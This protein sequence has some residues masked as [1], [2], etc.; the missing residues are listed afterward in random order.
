[1]ENRMRVAE[2]MNRIETPL[3]PA[4]TLFEAAQQ[5]AALGVQALPVCL[6]GKIVGLLTDEDLVFGAEQE[7]SDGDE[8]PATAGRVDR[9]MRPIAARCH[10]DDPLDEVLARAAT[11]GTRHLIVY[12]DDEHVTGVLSL[13][14]SWFGEAADDSALAQL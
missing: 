8:V 10:E 9:A 13:R 7:D 2:V 11:E 6:N 3:A 4:S 12:D 14:A 1:M 5:F